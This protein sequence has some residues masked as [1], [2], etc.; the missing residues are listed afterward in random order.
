MLNMKAV[1]IS[2]ILIF[3]LTDFGWFQIA[4]PLPP[5]GRSPKKQDREKSCHPCHLEPQAFC[6]S[7][8]AQGPSRKEGEKKAEEAICAMGKKVGENA[9]V[10]VERAG[11]RWDLL[12]GRW[13]CRE[14]VY[15][16]SKR[17]SLGG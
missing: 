17:H 7:E 1:L 15:P 16:H 9:R 6:L 14:D 8:C 13:G 5:S 10:V 12:G 4:I 2:P 11:A 3:S